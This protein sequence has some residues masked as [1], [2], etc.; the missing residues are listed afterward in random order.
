[1]LKNKGYNE[2]SPFIY[3]VLMETLNSIFNE[4]S[5]Y[6]LFLTLPLKQLVWG[7]ESPFMLQL[8]NII[9]K[10]KKI[11]PKFI[12]QHLNLPTLNPHIAMQV[13]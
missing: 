4:D 6:S 1:M 5:T 8:E 2:S 13:K 11:L 12:W 7:Y 10:V 9:D 3:K